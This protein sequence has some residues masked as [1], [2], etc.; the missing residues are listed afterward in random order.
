LEGGAYEEVGRHVRHSAKA[1]K[2]TKAEATAGENASLVGPE[3]FFDS[4]VSVAMPGFIGT[5]AQI[6]DGARRC[7]LHFGPAKMTISDVSAVSGLSRQSIYKYFENADDLVEAVVS[8]GFTML[9]LEL[10]AAMSSEAVLVD[11]ASA[12]AVVIYK[13]TLASRRTGIVTPQQEALLFTRESMLQTLMEAVRPFV[14]SARDREEVRAG[15]NIDAAAEWLARVVL[16]LALVPPQ[17]FDPL[18][19]KAVRKFMGDH[20]V[21]GFG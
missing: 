12:A 7:M 6:V 1:G 10:E 2:S 8:A 13:W 9:T 21:T 18:D 5:K 11:Q 20:L 19:R 16:S 4:N 3:A 17:T 15:L 14:Q